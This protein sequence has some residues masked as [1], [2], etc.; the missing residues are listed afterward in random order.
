M[1]AQQ[2]LAELI[3]KNGEG[4]PFS[5]FSSWKFLF[6]HGSAIADL[7]EAARRALLHLPVEE[8]CCGF[9]V[10]GYADN[11]YC[12]PP[13]CCGNPVLPY[14]ELYAA[15]RKLTQDATT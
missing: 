15:L 1:T 10:G 11:D 5:Y 8:T 3:R 6:D 13:S 9:P 14:S 4:A 2:Q 12:E 7:L